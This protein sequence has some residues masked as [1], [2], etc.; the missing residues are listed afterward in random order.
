MLPA[1]RSCSRGRPGRRAGARPLGRGPAA[2]GQGPHLGHA[3]RAPGAR[4]QVR[5]ASGPIRVRT[6]RR[7]GWPTASHM[8]R[9]WRLRPSWMTMRSTPGATTPTRGRRRRPV[10]ELDALAQAS[11]GARATGCPP[12]R[13]GTPWPPRGRGGPA[14]GPARRRWSGPAGPRC[15]CR[16]GRPGRPGARR[17]TRSTTVGR[18]WG[19]AAVVT[20]PAGLFS[21]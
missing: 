17:G 4:G 20:T 8:R 13:P 6:R 3:E 9:T 15:P 19:S 1:A 12:P 2:G 10:V 11:Q 16:A 5:S 7:T 14:A 18:P 21:R